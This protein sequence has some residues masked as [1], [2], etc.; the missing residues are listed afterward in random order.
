[1]A[2]LQVRIGGTFYPWDVAAPIIMSKL[3]FSAPLGEATI[4]KLVPIQIPSRV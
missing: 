4:G 1:M 2:R 3:V